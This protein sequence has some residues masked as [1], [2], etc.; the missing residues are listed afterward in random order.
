MGYYQ[1]EDKAFESMIGNELETFIV[2][3]CKAPGTDITRYY[4]RRVAF[5]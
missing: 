3:K 2:K 1:E 4:N 5:A